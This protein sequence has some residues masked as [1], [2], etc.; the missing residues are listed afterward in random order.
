MSTK[1]VSIP[2]SVRALGLA[3][4]DASAF[5]TIQTE[6]AKNKALQAIR[7]GLTRHRE[8]ILKAN[9]KDLKAGKAAGLGGALMDRLALNER[10]MKGMAEAID[11]VL[12]L[13][14]PIAEVLAGWRRPN[15]LEIRQVRVP[16][17]LVGMIYESRPN[18]TIDA[19]A[20]CL[21]SG[22]AVLLKGG[23]EAFHSN[24]ALVG[25][26]QEA[27]AKV[28]WPKE[29][30]QL[31][32]F[33]DRSA[34]KAMMGL[35]GVLDVLIPRGG[36]GLIQAVVQGAKVPTLETG[37]GN[38]HLYVDATAD[39]DNAVAITVNAK[40]Q[41][42]GV[43][44]A[45]ETLLVHEAV[46][47]DFLPRVAQVLTAKGVELRGCPAT[48]RIIDA[49]PATKTDWDTEYLDLILAIRVVP[50][51]DE[52]IAH[53]RAHGTQHSETILTNDVAVAQRFTQQVDAAD[54]FV[55]A[56]SRFAD[57]GEYGFGAEIGIATQKLHARGPMGLKALTTYK[58]IVQG[59][60]Q[61]RP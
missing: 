44:N 27:L 36:A 30:V 47:G 40:T 7:S 6:A 48:R 12:G 20:L 29:A 50:S 22:N 52:A 53:I 10:R 55:N 11:V 15:G 54:V 49:T 38:C 42:P 39:L 61:I 2:A 4:K 59:S 19:A 43:C 58:Y 60:G 8:T 23:K 37:V 5:V 14:D 32:P 24:T 28:K 18:V 26:V 31:V 34:T 1:T 45:I 13:P 35:R 56:S 21:K 17:G 57:G 16:L 3:G 25:V 9:A 33:T 46:A 51:V 41:R